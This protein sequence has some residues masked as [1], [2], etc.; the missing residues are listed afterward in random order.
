MFIA[1]LDVYIFQKVV[2]KKTQKNRTPGPPLLIQD[3]RNFPNFINF[4]RLPLGVQC[5]KF[6]FW[7]LKHICNSLFAK[8]LTERRNWLVGVR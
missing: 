3:F 5:F 1:F 6:C 8:I 4:L 7:S 2:T